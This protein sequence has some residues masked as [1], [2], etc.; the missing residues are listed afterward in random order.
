MRRRGLRRKGL[1]LPANPSPARAGASCI[2]DALQVRNSLLFGARR[3]GVFEKDFNSARKIDFA[4]LTASAASLTLPS[5][6]D[7][8]KFQAMACSD[9]LNIAALETSQ[10]SMSKNQL[11]DVLTAQTTYRFN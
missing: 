4:R 9:R 7:V 5:L 3:S 8:A 10:S 1:H 11:Q 6:I 2:V